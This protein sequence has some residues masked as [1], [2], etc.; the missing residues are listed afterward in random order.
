MPSLI[1]H[2]EVVSIKARSTLKPKLVA[3]NKISVSFFWKHILAEVIRKTFSLDNVIVSRLRLFAALFSFVE[4]SLE[5]SKDS[6]LE[7]FN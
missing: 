2:T 1:F 7:N 5:T 3:K 6:F 4:H